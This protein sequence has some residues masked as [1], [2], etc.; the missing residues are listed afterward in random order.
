MEGGARGR[1]RSRPTPRSATA[2]RCVGY[3]KIETSAPDRIRFRSDCVEIDLGGIGKGYAVDRAIAVLKAA[4]IRHALVNAGG[5]SI[6]AIGAPP[7]TKGWPVRL[8]ARAGQDPAAPGQVDVDVA[9]ESCRRDPRSSD[10]IARREP[11][12]PSAS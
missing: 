8:G 3:E 9:T 5:S 4:G 6:A 1:P 7:G 2:R 11:R 12:W 10:R